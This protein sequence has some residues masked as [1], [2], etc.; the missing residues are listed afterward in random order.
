MLACETS[1]SHPVISRMNSTS[2]ARS[3]SGFRLSTRSTVKTCSSRIAGSPGFLPRGKL[4][5]SRTQCEGD[6]RGGVEMDRQ[7]DIEVG[8]GRE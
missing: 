2:R 7:V 4:H 3:V 1:S 8:P 6:A 5:L